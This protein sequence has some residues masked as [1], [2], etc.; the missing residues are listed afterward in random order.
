MSEQYPKIVILYETFNSNSGGG[1]TL[2]NLFNGWDPDKIANVVD[3]PIISQITNFSNCSNY[4]TLGYK[5]KITFP[6]LSVFTTKFPSG[7]YF[8]NYRNNITNEISHF[9]NRSIKN[10][11]STL[12]W[13]FLKFIGLYHYVTKYIISDE[14]K[15]WLTEFKP[16]IIYSQLSNFEIIDFTIMLKKETGAKLAVHIMDDWFSSFK[17]IGFCKK[18]WNKI[19]NQKLKEIFDLADIHLSISE[20]MTNEYKIRFDKDFSPFHNPIDTSIWLPYSKKDVSI[21]NKKI[22][23]LYAGRIGKGTSVS[24]IEIAKA[25]EAL[26]NEGI[27]ICF[28]IQTTIIDEHTKKALSEIK[29]VIFNPIVDLS[30]LPAIFSSADIL[31]MPIDFT[32]QGISF[33]KYSMPTKAS[34]YMIS[35]TPILLYCHPDVSLHAHAQKYKWAYVVDKQNHVLLKESIKKLS[36]DLKLREELNKNA[37]KFSLENFDSLL[38]KQNFRKTLNQTI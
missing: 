22:E 24:V 12:L 2:T 25:V 18:Y 28:K 33:L 11:I 7:K 1:I 16:D 17:S 30:R 4:Y 37:V 29:S 34:E 31:V 13:N 6:L 10:K 3:Y 21:Q 19:L 23:V 27:N 36:N 8:V 5:E 38:V 14:L 35:G 26:S 15:L 20:G 32:A 9:P